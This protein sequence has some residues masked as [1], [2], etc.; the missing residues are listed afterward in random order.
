MTA[1]ELA[2]WAAEACYFVNIYFIVDD[3]EAL[4]R[5]GRIPSSVAVAGAKLDVK[6]LLWIAV[7]GS[8]AIK[9][10]ARS[11]KKGLKQLASLYAE[12]VD[13]SSDTTYVCTG[14]ADCARDVRK[15]EEYISKRV[16]SPC[17]SRGTSD[18]SWEATCGRA[19]WRWLSGD[20]TSAR[21]FRWPIAS[22]ARSRA[23]SSRARRPRAIAVCIA[24]LRGG[25]AERVCG[26][27]RLENAGI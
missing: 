16:A 15:L 14:T 27:R 24:R 25:F 9:G 20:R 22:H 6:P 17:S 10:I 5:G 8:L 19:W 18:R 21:S 1:A 13:R 7:D 4:R 12:R 26:A 23:G 3:L 11:R 2:A